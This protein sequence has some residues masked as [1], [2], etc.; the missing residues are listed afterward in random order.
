[1]P[2]FRVFPVNRRQRAT[3]HALH[4]LS[5]SKRLYLL[6]YDFLQIARRL[7]YVFHG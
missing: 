6:D 2:I 5:Q 1:M 7:E 4:N 3:I